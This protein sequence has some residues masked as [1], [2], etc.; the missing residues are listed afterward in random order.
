MQ[1][2][3]L[4][5]FPKEISRVHVF[6]PR[7][8]LLSDALVR[9]VFANE[10]TVFQNLVLKKRRRLSEDDQIDIPPE[11]AGQ[12]RLNPQ[13]FAARNCLFRN[14]RQIEIAAPSLPAGRCGSEQIDSREPFLSPKYG[15]QFL[16]FS[17]LHGTF[18]KVLSNIKKVLS[19]E[20]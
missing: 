13:A 6:G 20:C 2:S 16:K 18:E 14:N 9:I 3:P 1:S 5:N 11:P 10:T 4:L 7:P 15:G 12:I 8:Y 17:V 19:V